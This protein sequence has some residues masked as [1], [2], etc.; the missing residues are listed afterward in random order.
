MAECV[1]SKLLERGG[2]RVKELILDNLK[3][4]LTSEASRVANLSRWLVPGKMPTPRIKPQAKPEHRY[5]ANMSCTPWLAL[6]VDSMVQALSVSGYRSSEDMSAPNEGAWL[7]WLGSR[8]PTRQYALYRDVL[9]YGSAY[10]SVLPGRLLDGTTRA[11]WRL[12]GAANMVTV[13]DSP[14][15]DEY[16]AY[17]LGRDGD[18]YWFCDQTAYHRLAIDGTRI[19]VLET[20]EHNLGVVPVVRYTDN[21]DLQGNISPPMEGLIPLVTR[22]SKN[23]YDRLLTQHHN[24]WRVKTITG[25]DIPE[26]VDDQNKMMLQLS[27]D[28]ILV[29]EDPDARFGSLPETVLDSF[30]NAAQEDLK[31]LAAVSCTPIYALTGTVANLS[32]DAITATRSA[33]VQKIQTK[34]EILGASHAQ[35]LRLASFIEGDL[36]SASNYAAQV[37]WDSREP[38]SLS[39]V[40]DALSKLAPLGIPREALFTM[41]PG[42]S[43][44]E[45]VSWADNQPAQPI[46]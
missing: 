24:S 18:T 28:D 44:E 4:L 7:S 3:P 1:S 37:H 25:L 43:D 34:Q 31:T 36:E 14:T 46:V 41:L 26:S 32:A 38:V 30:I 2:S 20:V 16:P 22:M 9:G 21:M 27:Q 42:V 19:T 39:Q 33:F 35:A 13:Y 10:V 11:V 40:A 12:W 17:A 6:V 15:S 5:L 23:V 45:A 8:M 29:A